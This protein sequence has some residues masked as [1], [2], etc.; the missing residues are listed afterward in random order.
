[1]SFPLV[2][3]KWKSYFLLCRFWDDCSWVSVPKQ[4][5]VPGLLMIVLQCKHFSFTPSWAF[6]I[7]RFEKYLYHY[8]CVFLTVFCCCSLFLEALRDNYCT[9]WMQLP[10]LL[11]FPSYFNLFGYSWLSISVLNFHIFNF[12]RKLFV[13]L[14]FF[15]AICSAFRVVF[16]PRFWEYSSFKKFIL[17]ITCFLW[18]Q[19]SNFVLHLGPSFSCYKLK[20][21]CLVI[22][23]G[24]L[25]FL[26]ESWAHLM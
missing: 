15:L 5:S 23:G 4:I 2:I 26:N 8:F 10:C 19:F 18:S 6:L 13:I 14:L 16:P 3:G 17:S 21:K 22:L 7:W 9:S 25:T 20:K 1:M 12:I 24:P 11:T